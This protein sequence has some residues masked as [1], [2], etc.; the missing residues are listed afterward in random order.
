M[1][2][3]ASCSGEHGLLRKRKTRPWFTASAAWRASATE[4]AK[5]LEDLGQGR[6]VDLGCGP[7]DITLRVLRVCPGWSVDA[8]DGS[9]AM[10][11]LAR[12]AADTAGLAARVRFIKAILPQD[13]AVLP[14]SL[15]SQP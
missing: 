15:P 9:P 6:V 10:L 13:Q 1:R 5:R 11:A 4:L 14:I 3:E 7:G 12:Q 2:V 8:L